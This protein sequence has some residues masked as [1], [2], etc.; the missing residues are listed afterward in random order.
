MDVRFSVRVRSVG[1]SRSGRR[2][3]GFTIPQV[4]CNDLSLKIGDTVQVTLKVIRNARHHGND[5]IS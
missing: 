4:I 1:S 5:C 2:S 3:L